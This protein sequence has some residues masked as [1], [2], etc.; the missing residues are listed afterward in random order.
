MCTYIWYNK[1]EHKKIRKTLSKKS[2]L[3]HIVKPPIRFISR[4][5]LSHTIIE[6]AFA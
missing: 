3:E 4:V 5:L 1:N 2:A 6:I